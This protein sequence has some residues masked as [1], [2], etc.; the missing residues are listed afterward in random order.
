[1]YWGWS[2][3]SHDV[4]NKDKHSMIALHFEKYD[5]LLR[6]T[7]EDWFLS[8]IYALNM[9]LQPEAMSLASAVPLCF[10]SLG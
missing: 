3:S 9:M 7:W 2:V 5:L 4:V 1:M 8:Q 6:A 10:K